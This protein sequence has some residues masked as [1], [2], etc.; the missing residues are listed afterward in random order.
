MGGDAM[1]APGILAEPCEWCDGLF[2]DSDRLVEHWAA[3]HPKELQTELDATE[4]TA[5]TAPTESAP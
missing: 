2:T 4:T 5:D 1:T 3:V